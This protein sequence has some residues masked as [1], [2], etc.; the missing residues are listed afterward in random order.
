M[1]AMAA[2]LWS[3]VCWALC[4]LTLSA[5][6]GLVRR[7]DAWAGVPLPAWRTLET[8]H[9]RLNYPAG[10]EAVAFRA[11]RICEEAHEAL[12]PM[13]HHRPT[14]RTEVSLSDFGDSANGSATAL[15]SNR[16]NLLAAP[17]G[18]DGNL[19][20]FDDW[21]RQLIYH[22]YTHILHLDTV[23]GWP[24]ALNHVFGKRFAPNQNMP[25]F[26]IEGVAVYVES[27]TSGRGRVRSAMFRGWLRTAALDGALHDLDAATHAPQTFPGPNVWYMYGGHFMDW[28]ARRHGADA[29]ARMFAVYGHDVVPFAVNRAALEA[30][31]ETITA[32][33]SAWQADVRTEAAAWRTRRGVTPAGIGKTAPALVTT[34]GERHE[35]PRFLPDGALLSIEGDAETETDVYDRGP[36]GRRPPE[37][38]L[39][40]DATERFDVCRRTGAL[41]FDQVN[42]YAGAYA[43][44]DLFLLEA[45][46]GGRT[47]RVRRLTR[48]A[49][50]RDPA[51]DPLG[52]FAVGV[53]IVAGR[54]RLVRVELDTGEIRVLY[55][56]GRL[57]LV[58]HPAISPDGRRVGFVRIEGGRRDVGLLELADPGATPS[59][60]TADDALE[61][62]P[63]F[64]PDGTG[65]LYASDR[66]GTFE[67]YL[68]PV[69]GGPARRV[70]NT[71]GGVVEGEISNDGR[72]L[73][74]ISVTADGL[75]LGTMVFD[76][77]T[78]LGHALDLPPGRAPRPD[79]GD[80]PLPNRPY[81]PTETLWPTVWAPKIA[82]SSPESNTQQVGLLLESTD[83]LAH[84]ALLGD[85]TT[86]PDAGG[87]AARLAWG[88]RR[89]IPNFALSAS[90]ETRVRD[91]G[92]FYANQRHPLRE[93]VSTLAGSVGLF[94]SRSGH[95]GSLSARLTGAWFRPTENATPR[96][97][98]LDP[99]PVLPE[100]SRTTDLSIGLSYRHTG[101]TLLA[102]SDET[103]LAFSTSLRLRDDLL[104]SDSQTAEA[105]FDYRHYVDL[106]WRH[107]LALRL[108]SAFGAGDD[109]RGIA[110]ALGPA[111]ERNLLLDALDQI[112]YG[113]TFFRGFPSGTATGSR[114]ALVT[115]EYRLPL[116]ELYRGFSMV[117]AFFRHVKLA[118]FTDWAQARRDTLRAYPSAFRKSAGVELSAHALLGWRLPLDGRIGYA[119]GFG[120]D[121][122]HQTYFFLGN[123]F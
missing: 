92:Q 110:Y 32:L 38:R 97:D 78:D 111:P 62:R 76:P 102:V 115:A 56:P 122:E 87:Y 44:T 104:G 95:A 48:G 103:G 47:G 21:L 46:R 10:L 37:V 109:R 15:P 14:E 33:W 88:Y 31:G 106:W 43:F 19:G 51:C 6:D 1:R 2:G 113:S 99:V 7:P 69:H 75:D 59:W 89:H 8:P 81:A 12:V 114:Y 70:T 22:E 74:T 16:M 4:A 118:F 27:Q 96:F 13:L 107:V 39:H 83:A 41:V 54:T 112:I 77:A 11:A 93:D 84:H 120:A 82:L 90:H 79:P 55:D 23:H 63:R 119:R 60:F 65:V 9:F 73:A 34:T 35:N 85:F 45:G 50:I 58:A 67:L 66:T 53:Q 64:S 42:T 52:R 25:S 86:R 117:P 29:L 26:L 36:D 72:M 57:D 3:M 28:V 20:D 91:G 17:P 71:V 61:L 101:R 5:L 24:R 80:R 105:F 68:Q 108:S 18:P 30:T 40:L 116:F 98:P 123:W 100:A 94:V 121:G 49:R